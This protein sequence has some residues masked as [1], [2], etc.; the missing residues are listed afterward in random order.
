MPNIPVHTVTPK[1]NF[2]DFASREGTFV[3][4]EEIDRFFSD[5]VD[6]HC[7]ETGKRICAFR[8]GI[9]SVALRRDM[10]TIFEPFA[11]TDGTARRIGDQT[12]GVMVA[13][14]MDRRDVTATAMVKSRLKQPPSNLG[15]VVCRQTVF[16]AQNPRGA[17]DRAVPI[18]QAIGKLHS[19][20][21]PVGYAQQEA[22]LD[23]HVSPELRIAG[24]AYTTVSVN[25]SFQT[26][27]HCDAGDYRDGSGMLV[28]AGRDFEGGQLCFPR[29]GIALCTE[30]GDFVAMDVH[31][32]HGNLPIVHTG[33]AGAPGF[34]LALIAYVR[35]HM[36]DCKRR[37]PGSKLL[38]APSHWKFTHQDTFD[39]NFADL[40]TFVRDHSRLPKITDGPLGEWCHN[41][42]TDYRNGKLPEERIRALETI[43]GW[44]WTVDDHR[45]MREARAKVN[46]KHA[47]AFWANLA[48]LEAHIDAHGGLPKVNEGPL[49][50][51]V[52]NRLQ[53]IRKKRMLPD[54]KKA[55]QRVLR[56]LKAPPTLPTPTEPFSAPDVDT[57]ARLPD[58][59]DLPE[60]SHDGCDTDGL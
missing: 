1:C 41:R 46:E 27:I 8:K 14:Y 33:A 45:D 35:E 9:V 32:W 24:T 43:P 17:W 48:A 40:Q 31:E 22:Y 36:A 37:V 18:L 7:A 26:R 4:P 49:G 60:P 55:F 58:L 51:W 12:A 10:E 3:T 20:I 30:P 5:S 25:R 53:D 59:P 56:R 16:T 39:N 57:P 34:R 52:D 38:M 28:V 6:V 47:A 42:R 11:R 15:R 23:Q 13:G 54:R 19:T 21:D 50:K 29:Y 2:R 44:T